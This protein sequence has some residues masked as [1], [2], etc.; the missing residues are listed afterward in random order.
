MRLAYTT[1]FHFPPFPLIATPAAP[2][3]QREHHD[4]GRHRPGE[5]ERKY[6]LI[7]D[8]IHNVRRH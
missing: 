7:A 3:H 2:E 1:S 4:P 5:I 8:I 6:I